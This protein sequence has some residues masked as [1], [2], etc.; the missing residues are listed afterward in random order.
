MV[1]IFFM[2]FLSLFISLLIQKAPRFVLSAFV[3]FI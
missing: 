1:S 2:H 3:L